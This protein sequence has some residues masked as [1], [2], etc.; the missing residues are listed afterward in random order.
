MIAVLAA[1][2]CCETHEERLYVEH[3]REHGLFY[4][5]DEFQH[6]FGIFLEALSHIQGH[7]SG[8]HGFQLG[9]NQFSTWTWPEYRSI[10][11]HIDSEEEAPLLRPKVTDVTATAPDTYSWVSLGVVQDVKDQGK[12]GSCWAFGSIG[13]QESLW[14]IHHN[15]LYSLS[16]QNLV[17]CVTTAKGCG[18]GNA[19]G[20]YRYVIQK[21]DG[22]FNL[23]T[24]Y[25]YE[26]KNGICRFDPS[27][28]ITKIGFAV[29]VNKNENDLL[30]AVWQYGP[31]AVAIDANHQS[32]SKYKTGVYLE[33]NCS[34]VKLDHEV[35]LVGWGV[36]PSP[37]WLVKNSWG[38]KWGED[39]FIRMAR[40]KSNNCG[41]ATQAT[42]PLP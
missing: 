12:C 32:F 30:S 10:L 16:E 28:A 19:Y 3:L 39:G 42:L 26:A 13:A 27:G 6:R 40:G 31:V 5:G 18:G 9:L 34:S 41:I 4:T 2:V 37:Y 33:L 14:A 25:P 23:E 7:N 24:A 35:L 8:S 22:A 1:L 20:A 11:G 21:Q 38:I 29:N 15:T 36:D 17:D